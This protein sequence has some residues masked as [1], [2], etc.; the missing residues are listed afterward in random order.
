MLRWRND[1]ALI[2]TQHSSPTMCIENLLQLGIKEPNLKFVRPTP[3][4]DSMWWKSKLRISNKT[5]VNNNIQQDT[6]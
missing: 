5:L 1:K 6:D 3:S 4:K 2:P